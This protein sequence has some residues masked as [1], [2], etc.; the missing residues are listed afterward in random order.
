MKKKDFKV[1]D[2]VAVV[3]GSISKDD[4][5]EESAMVGKVVAVGLQDMFVESSSAYPYSTHK[6]SKSLCQKILTDNKN[7]ADSSRNLKPKVGD[8]VIS[9][10]KIGHSGTEKPLITGVL[11]KI[12]YTLGREDMCTILEGTDF[13]QVKFSS[14]LV[15]QKETSSSS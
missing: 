2:L 14:L 8:L 11:Y 15:L 3:G 4:K 9:Y 7:L 10:K 12:T 13:H 6:V 1:G 5:I